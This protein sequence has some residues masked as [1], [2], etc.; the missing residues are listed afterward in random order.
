M[1]TEPRS[2]IERDDFVANDQEINKCEDLT[3]SLIGELFSDL[4]LECKN[5]T[6]DY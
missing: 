4:S 3:T 1:I 6:Q 5:Y 2:A